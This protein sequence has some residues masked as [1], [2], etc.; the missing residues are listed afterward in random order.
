[1]T[2][3]DIAGPARAEA[4]KQDL[5]A[6]YPDARIVQVESYAPDRDPIATGD[7]NKE[8]RVLRPHISS[9]FRRELVE[10]LQAAHA[11]LLI[12]PD[13]KQDDDP[14]KTK[15]W[16]P[17]VKR[18]V[19]WDKMLKAEGALVGAEIGA[20]APVKGRDHGDPEGEDEGQTEEEPEFLT[21]GLIG[22]VLFS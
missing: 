22:V 4:W 2:K 18:A 8:R 13:R 12:P 21:V 5:Q 9:Q 3:V 7:Q 14:E 11:D 17:P 20:T 10:A 16:T 6:R 19:D 15:K 1:M